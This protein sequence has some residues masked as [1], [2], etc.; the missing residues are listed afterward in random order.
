MSVCSFS[1]ITAFP[2][3]SNELEKENKPVSESKAF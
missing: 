2:E 1:E 3:I